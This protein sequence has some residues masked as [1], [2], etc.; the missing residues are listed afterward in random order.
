MAERRNR[1]RYISTTRALMRFLAKDPA[2]RTRA[3]L[4]CQ[5]RL[6]SLHARHPE[7]SRLRQ[8]STMV[9]GSSRN[10]ANAHQWRRVPLQLHGLPPPGSQAWARHP[11]PA[12]NLEFYTR[13]TRHAL[14]QNVRAI[15]SFAVT[16]TPSSSASGSVSSTSKTPMWSARCWRKPAPIPRVFPAYLTGGGSGGARGSSA[17]LPRRLGSSGCRP[18]FSTAELFLGPRALA[19]H[20]RSPHGGVRLAPEKKKDN[21]PWLSQANRKACAPEARPRRNSLSGKKMP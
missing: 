17:A 10:S 18:L 16:M 8:G 1:P 13:F 21:R 9:A 2:Y 19:R 12:E 6:A 7:L 4:S 14:R 3:G 15:R 11:R 5:G 20:P